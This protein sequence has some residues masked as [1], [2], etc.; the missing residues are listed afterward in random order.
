ML[1]GTPSPLPYLLLPTCLCCFPHCLKGWGKLYICFFL[2]QPSCTKAGLS[3]EWGPGQQQGWTGGSPPP[4]A[5]SQ[6]PGKEEELLSHLAV[7]IVPVSSWAQSSA[8]AALE[9]PPPTQQQG[10]AGDMG[11][12]DR[13]GGDVPLSTS[14]KEGGEVSPILGI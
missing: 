6:G 7:T 8:E 4:C 3:W 14:G 9:L 5:F 12:R 13:R 10:Q 11:D 2:P 1:R